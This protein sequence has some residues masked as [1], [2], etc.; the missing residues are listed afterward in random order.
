MPRSAVTPSAAGFL[1]ACQ[2]LSITIR[3]PFSVF[4]C[5][6]DQHRHR[7]ACHRGSSC[8]ITLKQEFPHFLLFRFIRLD[9]SGSELA[10]FNV[11]P[12]LHRHVLTHLQGLRMTDRDKYVNI[13]SLDARARVTGLKDHVVPVYDQLRVHWNY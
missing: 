8:F 4:G 5:C 10:L 3:F 6:Q 11:A 2:A 12:Y 1:G 7:N 13:P 9:P